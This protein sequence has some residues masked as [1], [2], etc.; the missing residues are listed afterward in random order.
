MA[1]QQVPDPAYAWAPR[2]P[3]FARDAGPVVLVD[4]SH[5]NVHTV[6]GQFRGFAGVARADGFRVHSLDGPLSAPALAACAV[7]VIAS[8]RHPHTLDSKAR[9]ILEAYDAGEIALLLG[10]VRRG[11][12]LLLVTDHMPIPGSMTA[13]A[14][15]FGFHLLDGFAT[16]SA[17]STARLP[18][19][20]RRADR[21]VLAHPVTDGRLRRERIDSVATFTGSAFTADR[22]ADPLLRLPTHAMVIM[23]DEPWQFRPDTPRIPG[24]G[25]LV[26]ATRTVGKGRVA[27]VAEAAMFTAQLEG[28]TGEPMGMNHPWAVQD[29]Q[30]VINL[31]HWL[32]GRLPAH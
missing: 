4:G 19:V 26:G 7:F 8:P 20:L 5:H 18:M 12:S 30:F 24:G 29:P 28:P 15:A 3:A 32:A 2:S 27:L 6:T 11:G 21:T 1:A 25:L 22:G 10:W 13:L 23:P 14:A 9:P 31:L 16:D 17:D